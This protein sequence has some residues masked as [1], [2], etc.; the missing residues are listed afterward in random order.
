MHYKCSGWALSET[1][2]VPLV[3][4]DPT[5]SSSV[6][7]LLTVYGKG[8]SNFLLLPLPPFLFPAAVGLCYENERI[9]CLTH[10]LK[11]LLFF[12]SLGDKSLCGIKCLFQAWT[13]EG[14][15]FWSSGLL[16]F[17]KIHGEESL[18]VESSCVWIFQA[19][20]LNISTRLAI[21]IH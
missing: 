11:F 7:K 18:G 9:G 12:S 4:S 14:G 2:H 6:K 20:F 16:P 3:L 21:T 5:P 1:A 15:I 13:M 19:L 17:M 10:P 8:K